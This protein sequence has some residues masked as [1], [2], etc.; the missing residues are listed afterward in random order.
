LTLTLSQDLTVWKDDTPIVIETVSSLDRGDTCTLSE[1]KMSLHSGTHVDAPR[2]FLPDGNGVDALDLNTLMGPVRVV[3]LR[4]HAMITDTVL[5]GSGIPENMERI[6]FLTD[7]T[8][9][10][11]LHASRFVSEF[12]AIDVSG[13]RWLKKMSIRLV[14]IDALSVAPFDDPVP[15][16]QALLSAGI[17]IVEGLNFAGVQ[18]GVYQLAVMPLKIKD[19]DGAPARVLLYDIEDG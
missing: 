13:A 15:T 9:K 8:E 19:A 5:S 6:L 12:T 7:N 2:H 16:H 17:I 11:I 4:G 1:I 3:D 10:R 14:G 18:P